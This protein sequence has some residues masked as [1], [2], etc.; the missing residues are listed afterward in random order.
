MKRHGQIFLT[1]L[2]VLILTLVS[3]VNAFAESGTWQRE[4]NGWWYRKADGSY[5]VNDWLKDGESWY[6]FN[7][8]GYMKTGW[9]QYDGIWY[10]LEENGA[11]TG[12]KEI[13]H[14]WYYFD[15]TGRMYTNYYIDDRYFVGEDGRWDGTDLA[16]TIPGSEQ[17]GS[18]DTTLQFRL[19]QK[20][21]YIAR[22]HLTYFDGYYIRDVYTKSCA[23]GKEAEVTVST[24]GIIKVA[25]EIWAFGWQETLSIPG[26][27]PKIYKYNHFFFVSSGTVFTPDL[28]FY[29]EP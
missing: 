4:Q 16:E 9:F 23:K 21:I 24:D 12:W 10:Y 17:D 2:T 13:D 29:L 14:E 25:L 20:G 6:Y 3:G 27:N 11:A 5:P 15:P 26:L 19:I 28:D 22:L 18:S 8:D 7:Q 1:M